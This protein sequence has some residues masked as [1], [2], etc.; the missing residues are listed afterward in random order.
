MRNFQLS[1]LYDLQMM[2]ESS[3]LY[4]KYY[5]LFQALGDIS[6]PEFNT[7]VGR[8]GYSK[9]AILRAFIL[10]H[11]EGIKSVPQLVEFL[12]SHP[13]MAELCGFKVRRIPDET[14]FYRFLQKTPNSIVKETHARLNHLLVDQGLVSLDTFIMDSKPVLA[15]TRDNN[16][17]NPNRKC[18]DKQRRPRRNPQ[19]TLS[20]YAYRQIENSSKK[21][22]LFY[23][24]YRSHVI[25]S[26]EG[27]CLVEKTLP[28]NLT[29]AEVAKKLIKELKRRFRFKKGTFFIGDKGYDQRDIYE[30]IITTL[31]GQAFIPLNPRSQ[32]ETVLGPNGFP[33]CEASLEM[34]YAGCWQE[35]RKRRIKYRCPIKSKK[36]IFPATI[37]PIN[38]PRF[39]NVYGCTRNLDVTV[40]VRSQVPRNTDF[41][42]SIYQQRQTV[43]QYFSR[44]G[45]KEVEQ[46]TH[47]RLRTVQNQMTIAHLCL[48]LVAV[49]AGIILKQPEK[50]RCVRT[51]AHLSWR[52]VA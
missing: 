23:W 10:K 7:G 4:Y 1:F 27:I 34:K 32:K 49:A 17:K 25:V 22:Y 26:A 45:E 48:S 42:K 29:D 21:E 9:H 28:N 41:F 50:I 44:L 31:K 51:F 14:R 12:R 13:V 18:Q 6:L 40:D 33:L 37:C 19:A 24:G 5:L 20:Y 16:F 35:G 52:K 2:V 11:L 47:Y 43:E 39:N 36:K 30:L 8:T 46:T 15:A 38:N 3:P